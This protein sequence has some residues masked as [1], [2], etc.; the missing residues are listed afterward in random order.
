MSL[1]SIIFQP[2]PVGVID[3]CAWG[4]WAHSEN[5]TAYQWLKDGVVIPGAINDTYNGFVAVP[6]PHHNPPEPG[7]YSCVVSNLD[8][9]VTSE[10]AALTLVPLAIT[11]HPQPVMVRYGEI[12]TFRVTVTG[13]IFVQWLVDGKPR[14]EGAEYSFAVRSETD[15]GTYSV[16]ASSC[17]GEIYS[18]GAALTV[19]PLITIT[20]QPQPV[21]VSALTPATFS[22]A[23]TGATGYQWQ[24]NG[25][26]ITGATSSTYSIDSVT[27]ADAGVYK[28]VISNPERN[29]ISDEAVLTI[30]VLKIITQPQSVYVDILG[31]GGI[32]VAGQSPLCS[33]SVVAQNATAYVWQSNG[34]PLPDN[35]IFSGIKSSQFA[36]KWLSAPGHQHAP[37][38]FGPLNK[39][40]CLV[41]SENETIISNE[42]YVLINPV[43][44]ITSPAS[45]V[46]DLG[47]SLYLFAR[48]KNLQFHAQGPTWE[49]FHNG[50]SVRD[51]A[52][53][54][55]RYTQLNFGSITKDDLGEWFIRGYHPYDG[56]YVDSDVAVITVN[57]ASIT[58]QPQS[59]SV[60]KGT[61]TAMSVVAKNAYA[62]QWE[63]NGIPI[64]G[65][66]NATY[67]IASASV[68]DAGVYSVVISNPNGDLVSNEASLSLVVLPISITA[69]PQALS[70]ASGARASFT[71]A[72]TNATTYQWTKNGVAIS[73]ATSATYTIPVV[74][75]SDLGRYSVV[76]SNPGT[77]VTSASAVLR[78]Y[79]TLP[80]AITRQPVAGKVKVG[81]SFT[82][83]VVASNVDDYQ[84]YRGGV[85]IAEA[86][87]STCVIAKVAG[88]DFG[89]YYVKLS[90]HSGTVNSATVTLDDVAPHIP[91]SVLLSATALGFDKG[92]V[93]TIPVF[94]NSTVEDWNC[95]ALPDGLEFDKEL[96]RISGTAT[97]TGVW[98]VG[99]TAINTYG[100]DTN[101]LTIEIAEATAGISTG[102]DLAV[103]VETKTVQLLGQP[104]PVG[105][106]FSVKGKDDV[107][108]FVRFLKRGLTVDLEV[109]SLVLIIKEDAES[110]PLVVSSDFSRQND[111]SG[112]FFV[113]RFSPD[114]SAIDALFTNYEG[115]VRTE[116]QAVAELS[117]RV[118]S[119][120]SGV[121]PRTYTNSS[122]IFPISVTRDLGQL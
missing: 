103:D 70:I 9:S 104:A 53:I 71:V 64:I 118:V 55:D 69:Q 1:P 25:V 16:I 114:S 76:I 23:A 11:E 38:T 26:N 37:F 102:I 72:A 109:T 47:S 73:G 88:V 95:T 100:T 87:A 24:K 89:D 67:S 21:A 97:L 40:S 36:V 19:D 83:S 52:I 58:T 117:W 99:I 108:L 45:A 68:T 106:V 42:V 82:L 57:P 107:L 78:F 2:R 59:I 20:A 94:S 116:F 111:A 98:V 44:V 79:Q 35:V 85:A 122:R 8:G 3:G 50:K 48:I 112:D 4:F 28:V 18:K 15:L 66:T 17:A 90:N 77:S 105:V 101:Y 32:L 46:V 113:L 29:L 110:A 96:G 56:T 30:A 91:P 61:A 34:I 86:T 60:G 54:S 51:Y 81:S 75:Q 74:A 63:K 5:A 12:A 31:T 39:F 7:I 84:W 49:W 22:V 121:G 80:I 33:F 65:A 27:V 10:G 92:E 43:E 14:G 6:V 119:P 13:A 120:W 62:Y 93:V 41:S 115:P